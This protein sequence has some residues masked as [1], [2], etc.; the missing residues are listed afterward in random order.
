MT[1]SFSRIET[2]VRCPLCFY[3]QYIKCLDS[4][5]GSFGQFGNISHSLLERYAKGELAEYELS[6]EYK[7]TYE[8]IVTDPF[9]PNKYVDLGERYYNQGLEFFNNFEGFGDIEVLGVEQE[10]RFKI[11]KY[12]FV[13]LIDLETPDSIIDHKTKGSQHLNRL[14]KKHNKEDYITM[15]DGRYIHK[16]NFRQLY[17]YSIPYKEKYGKYPKYLIL[18]MIR[19]NDWYCI[20]FNEAHFEEAKQWTIK[21]IE[22]IY[23]ATEFLKGDEVSEFWCNWVCS[24]R[25][26]CVHSERYVGV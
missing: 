24:Q 9:P 17:I 11:D 22:A 4:I 5:S 16:D 7:N 8:E 3:L 21:Q 12:N 23:N 26:N 1:F 20:E 18:N 6:R 10:Y 25:F 15:V 2:F 19:V 14:T 13:G